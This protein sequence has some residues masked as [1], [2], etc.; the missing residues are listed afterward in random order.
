MATLREMLCA[1]VDGYK[2]YDAGWAIYSEMPLALENEARLGQTQ[3]EQGGILD[4]KAFFADGE[5]IIDAISEYA[6]ANYPLPADVLDAFGVQGIA[7][8]V[9]EDLVRD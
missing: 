8:A 7:E 4:G 5:R 6:E 1:V 2:S 9:F 3:F